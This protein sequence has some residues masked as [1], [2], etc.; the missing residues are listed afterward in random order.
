[1]VD[2]KANNI[3]N[4]TEC[5]NGDSLFHCLPQNEK[6]ILDL[7]KSGN[8]YKKGQVIFYENNYPHGFYCIHKG[9]VKISKLG[10]E[11]KEQIVRF[12]GTAEL[13]GYR[14]VFGN[15]TYK[16]TATAMEDSYICHI[17]SDSFFKVLNQNNKL[18]LD[19]IRL[20]SSDLKNSEQKL[21]NI[22]Q[23]TAK[24]RIAETLLLIKT[25]FGYMDDG[26]TLSAIITR[27]EIGDIAG[28]TTETT[29]R[30]L[31][32]FKKEGIIDLIGR[33]ISIIDLEKLVRAA[34]IID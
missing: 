16:A 3:P 33:K 1:M 27:A 22:S 10:A 2:R 4:C 24:E 23:K 19:V 32:I 15:E 11:G 18:S 21:I 14:S 12:A 30:T 29:I 31:S 17:S 34:N 5:S 28:T 9:K 6:E 13:L 8:F 26:K 20:L 25:K 7:N